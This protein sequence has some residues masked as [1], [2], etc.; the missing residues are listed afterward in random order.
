[1]KPVE[2][3]LTNAESYNWI[4]GLVKA[5]QMHNESFVKCE[6][7]FD[8]DKNDEMYL[9]VITMPMMNG[10]FLEEIRK[11]SERK[12]W[13]QKAHCFDLFDLRFLCDYIINDGNLNK[14]LILLECAQ[15]CRNI[16]RI[17]VKIQGDSPEMI[18]QKQYRDFLNSIGEK[19]DELRGILISENPD[20][21]DEINAAYRGN[22]GGKTQQSIN[23][24]IVKFKLKDNENVEKLNKLYVFL[25]K[26]G[27]FDHDKLKIEDFFE[28]MGNA[29]FRPFY[30]ENNGLRTKIRLIV[31]FIHKQGYYP[32]QWFDQACR[33]LEL[34]KTQMG[35]H[36][37][38]SASWLNKWKRDFGLKN[39]HDSC[40]RY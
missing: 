36:D 31:H 39:E 19:L 3:I 8:H 33:L 9:Y 22:I 14:G 34:T 26:D 7:A 15:Y 37:K 2:Q 30:D 17:M 38:I 13:F 11:A 32:E 24:D 21:K 23:K 29:D 28:L 20:R 40:S 25:S 35:R 10:F 4:N 1:M 27:W 18:C 16:N 6:A 12:Y 5:L